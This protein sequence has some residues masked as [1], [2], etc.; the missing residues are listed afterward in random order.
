MERLPG[1][2]RQPVAHGINQPGD[3]IHRRFQT[4]CFLRIKDRNG[5]TFFKIRQPVFQPVDSE[6]WFKLPER[7]KCT[8]HHN[9]HA[10]RLVILICHFMLQKNPQ[11]ARCPIC[12][13]DHS[14]Q[15]EK[16]F[17]IATRKI[18]ATSLQHERHIGRTQ[19]RNR[20]FR[21]V[22]FD[23]DILSPF[24]GGHRT[25]QCQSIRR[26]ASQ[27]ARQC[28]ERVA[29]GGDKEAERRMP[30]FNLR[31]QPDWNC[32]TNNSLLCDKVEWSRL[33]AVNQLFPSSR[34]Q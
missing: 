20:F 18:V 1:I 23:P 9:M 24:T 34:S 32:R 15:P 12:T 21:A 30:G 8:N 29:I 28:L 13:F 19:K 31:T 14:P 2:S 25:V 26:G 33:Q 4:Q 11:A 5:K 17:C 6:S 10:V 16:V 27:P 7:G 3:T 22:A